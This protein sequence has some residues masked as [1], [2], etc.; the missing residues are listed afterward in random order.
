M[1]PATRL[2]ILGLVWLFLPLPLLGAA[3]WAAPWYAAVPLV[4]LSM[5]AGA[6]VQRAVVAQAHRW[7]R[8]LAA[9]V[10]AIAL[11]SSLRHS[12]L[13]TP[14][15]EL[16]EATAKVTRALNDLEKAFETSAASGRIEFRLP[17]PR[18]PVKP[19]DRRRMR[20]MS[21]ISPRSVVAWARLRYPELSIRGPRPTAA[22]RAS[23]DGDIL[24][25]V[26][27]ERRAR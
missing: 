14:Y 19:G 3:R 11:A 26:V 23:P 8:G 13:W 17:P 18:M 21:S 15:P 10:V 20:W 2:F 9:A 4:G 12:P 16:D 6:L 5:I 22:P 25:E 24:L 27:R 1:A 7:Q